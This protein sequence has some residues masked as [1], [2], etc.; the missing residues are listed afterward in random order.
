MWNLIFPAITPI[1]DKV[2]DLIPNDN[3]RE[4]AREQLTSDMQKAVQEAALQQS[5]ITEVEAAHSSVFVAGA[6]P[7]LLWI[8]GVGLAWT[9]LGHPVM[10]WVYTYYGFAV[11]SLPKLETDGL[12]ELVLAMLGLGGMR[13]FEKVKGVSRDSLK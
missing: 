7:F 1:I 11:E 10:T 5:K 2:L 3:E 12:F 8:C 6:R 4:R 9:Y 13:T